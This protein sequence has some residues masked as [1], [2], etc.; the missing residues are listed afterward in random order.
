MPD[1]DG[2][3][4]ICELST[5]GAREKEVFARFGRTAYQAQVFDHG[6]MIRT[7]G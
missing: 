4:L 3:N 1:S 7:C 2:F 5:D 6:A